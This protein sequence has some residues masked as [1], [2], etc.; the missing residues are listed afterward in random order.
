MVLGDLARHG[1]R[2]GHQIRR[3]AEMTNVGSWGGVSVGA[4]YRELRHMEDEGLV[5]PVRTEKVGRRPARTIYR[6][7]GEGRRELGI[8]R[9]KA[10][11]ELHHGPDALGVALVFGGRGARDELVVLLHSRRQALAHVLEELRG[12]RA[13]LESKG[14]LSLSDLA[15]FR[16]AEIHLSAEL[17]WHEEFDQRLLEAPESVG[18][19]TAPGGAAAPRRKNK[20]R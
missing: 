8:L 7:T 2:H 4:L 10:F 5:E 12:K 15:V 1:P 13:F 3:D 14:Y 20:S 18:D 9:K 19:E 16:R 17:T 6:I 11:L